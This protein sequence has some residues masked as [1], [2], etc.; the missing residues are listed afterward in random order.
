IINCT[1]TG[2]I[3]DAAFAI[4][5]C[6]NI[7]VINCSVN[8]NYCND[9]FAWFTSGANNTM[10][11]NNF[12]STWTPSTSTG[13]DTFKSLIFSNSIND[14][15]ISNNN[16][17][18][19]MHSLIALGGNMD[20]ITF[21]NNLLYN[22]DYY[23]NPS[24]FPDYSSLNSTIILDGMNR[25]NGKRI[26]LFQDQ[27]GLS[28]VDFVDIGQLFLDNC[29]S[30]NV[31][32][33]DYMVSLSARYCHNLTFHNNTFQARVSHSDNGSYVNNTGDYLMSG[34]TLTN[35]SNSIIK[36]NSYL[37]PT[38]GILIEDTSSTNNT[39]LNNNITA[40]QN[41]GMTI[42]GTSH[43]V[44]NNTITNA[45]QRAIF[46]RD[47]TH[48]TFFN[49]TI[50]NNT[51]AFYITNGA[52]N[53][54]IYLNKFSN[55][56]QY[57]SATIGILD[58]HWDD[59]KSGNYWEEYT[60]YYTSATNDGVIWNQA[61]TLNRT[62]DQYPLVTPFIGDYTPSANFSLVN[63]SSTINLGETLDFN[64]TGQVGNTPSVVAWNF[65][66]GTTATGIGT[67][68]HQFITPGTFS[69][70]CNVTDLDG[71]FSEHSIPSLV[72]VIDNLPFSS[73]HVSNT[74]FLEGTTIEINFTGQ[75]GD[76]P[77]MLLWDFGDGTNHS[78]NHL[79]GTLNHTYPAAGTYNLSLVVT[80]LNSNVSSS[81]VILH[82]LDPAADDDGDGLTNEEEIYG[83]TNPL[84][85]NDPPRG[86]NTLTLAI[87][88]ISTGGIFAVVA[89]IVILRRKN[90]I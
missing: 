61:Y 43:N 77:A 26:V 76:L 57:V 4:D 25:V 18:T 84:D 9:S 22:C 34:L 3:I 51:L 33:I 89:T 29:S 72:T 16:I 90:R 60:T 10:L 38:D 85:P 70:I 67:V 40:A 69:I 45:N 39:I 48:S 31:S 68:S 86:N 87:I 15:N 55:S 71:D 53:N 54:T 74:V 12:T 52:Y 62:Y 6:K 24:S 50:S 36:D 1:I 75:A 32:N 65:G 13:A 14:Y 44:T 88:L 47:L 78:G 59:G 17:S 21:S 79:E 8:V 28:P 19:T 30:A 11:N 35:C 66:D 7:G 37:L 81:Y 58:N 82:V 83:G 73:F 41:F 27:S 5:D 23:L 2:N 46:V 64:F 49:N 80:D 63:A 20:N 56:P 42:I